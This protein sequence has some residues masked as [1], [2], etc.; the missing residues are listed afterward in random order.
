VG[1]VA[2]SLVDFGTGT[3]AIFAV[4][5]FGAP[6]LVCASLNVV[7]CEA[8][9]FMNIYSGTSA[10]FFCLLVLGV[11]RACI[12]VSATQHFSEYPTWAWHDL[13][14]VVESGFD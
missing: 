13:V 1:A 10:N 2:C 3:D 7:L 12:H 8:L 11:C 6:L 9:G 4:S 5:A 14:I